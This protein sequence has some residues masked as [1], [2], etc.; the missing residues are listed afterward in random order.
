MDGEQKVMEQKA[1]DTLEVQSPFNAS[2]PETVLSSP[3]PPVQ[4]HS[5]DQTDVVS[6]QAKNT[7]KQPVS[8]ESGERRTEAIKRDA[9]PPPP[10]GNGSHDDSTIEGTE[11]PAQ[12]QPAGPQSNLGTAQSQQNT[13]EVQRPTTTGDDE[14][15]SNDTTP[16][17]ESSA[18]TTPQPQEINGTQ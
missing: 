2:K 14:P 17:T 11:L 13:M 9:T 5:V 8:S 15:K 16:N 12:Q 6:E 10:P 1:G 18:Q 3:P 4:D 7:Q